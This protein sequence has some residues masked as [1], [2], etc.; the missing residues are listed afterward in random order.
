M[1]LITLSMKHG[2]TPKEA[3]DRLETAVGD[4][5][6]LLGS[7]VRNTDW[8]P[9]RSRVRLDGTGFWLEMAVDAEDVTA[10]GDVPLLG[11]ILGGPLRPS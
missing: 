9:D 5:R 6:N 7:M 11:G 3:R 10:T 2:R 1:S 4:V 8:S